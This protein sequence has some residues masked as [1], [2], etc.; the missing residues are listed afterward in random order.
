MS[1]EKKFKR[2]LTQNKPFQDERGKFLPGN[3]IGK[4]G[5]RPVGSISL[6]TILKNI[7]EDVVKDPSNIDKK[8][9]GRLMIEKQIKQA[10]NDGDIQTQKLIW[11]YIEGLPK[12]SFDVTSMGE[13]IEGVVI[14][15]A[16]ESK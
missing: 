16:K 10:I 5:G 6:L 1:K 8:N 12:G 2:D 7:L 15:P 13:K 11:N 9:Y 4:L 14:L 3:E